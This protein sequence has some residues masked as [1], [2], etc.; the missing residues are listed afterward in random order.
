MKSI[1]L[2]ENKDFRRLY[3]RGKSCA[4][5]CV[6][7]YAM[8]SRQSTSRIGITASKKIG[9]AVERNRAKRVIRAAFTE[10]EPRICGVYDFVFVARTRT[11]CVKMQ[12]V[13]A[14]MESHFKELG[15][16]KD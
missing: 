16:I 10:L 14:Q 7:T 2:K 4:S 8:K 13:K 3:H 1:A 15:V 6:V 9:G 5:S 11:T 12:A